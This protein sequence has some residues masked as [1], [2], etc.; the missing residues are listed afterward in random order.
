[1]TENVQKRTGAPTRHSVSSRDEAFL[2]TME[3][4]VSESTEILVLIRYS[5]AAGSKSFEFFQSYAAL[6]EKLGR[7]PPRTS[8][9]AFR[10][11]QL[12]LRGVVEDKFIASCLNQISD[13]SEFL[14]VETVPRTAGK[15]SWIHESA[16]V[17]HVELREALEDSRGKAVA[18]GAYPPWLEESPD[19]I[20]A[21]VPDA[22]G[23]I[24]T[25][26][27]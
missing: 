15:E 17:S 21:I 12:P 14:V 23:A 1:M 26:V 22:H 9:I 24:T 27:Y 18:V 7:L 5:H 13:G 3:N 25:G 16:G 11:P 19:V 10:K 8:I 2:R 4:W 6:L 20:V